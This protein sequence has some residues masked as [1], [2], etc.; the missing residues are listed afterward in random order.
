MFKM[1]LIVHLL[2]VHPLTT[3][4]S[5][6]KL[7]VASQEGGVVVLRARREVEQPG[8]LVLDH[9]GGALPEHLLLRP[10][11]ALKQGAPQLHVL[12]A[13]AGH[14][15][16]RRPGLAARHPQRHG[17]LQQQLDEEVTRGVGGEGGRLGGHGQ[18][19][20]HQLDLAQPR[21]LVGGLLSDDLTWRAQEGVD[22]EVGDGG[23]GVEAGDEVLTKAEAGDEKLKRLTGNLTI[24]GRD[25][26][27]LRA[28][29]GVQRLIHRAG[30]TSSR[31]GRSS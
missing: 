11:H 28:D 9:L 25:G 23:E 20:R 31:G 2:F 3:E 30:V 1:F 27:L 10:A 7:D 29:P 6:H 16:A 26:R 18:G 17:R 24:K 8:D 19:A 12:P 14:L 22:D 5:T 4:K 21:E 15:V 13:L